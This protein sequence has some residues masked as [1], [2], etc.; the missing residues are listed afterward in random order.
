MTFLFRVCCV[1]FCISLCIGCGS[2]FAFAQVSDTFTVRTL[3]GN[4][5]TP[6]S[7]PPWL[8]VTPVAST[9]LDIAWATSTDDVA[10]GGYHVWRDGVLVATSTSTFY[11]DT[12]RTP[13]TTYT[14]Y[15]TAFDTFSNESAS[16]SEVSGTTF[17]VYV[18][19]PAEQG[20][21]YGTRVSLA[22]ELMSLSVIPGQHS[23]TIQYTT[24][25][26]VRG[27]IRYG[28]GSTYELGSLDEDV[29]QRAHEGRITGLL[30]GTTYS[31]SIEGNLGSGRYGVLYT[32]TFHTTPSVDTF[33]PGNVMNLHA[34]RNGNDVHL[35]WDNP[36]DVDFSHVRV[37]RGQLFYPTQSD[38]GWRVYD[39]EKEEAYDVGSARTDGVLYYTVFAYDA[40][41]NV[42]SGAVVSIRIGDAKPEQGPE[43]T[44]TALAFV[45]SDITFSQE[46]S[47]RPVVQ[48][49]V[50]IDGS[51]QLTV[52]IPYER[53][54]EHLKTI[55]IEITNPMDAQQPLRF[56]LRAD[57]AFTAYT[58]TIA[59]LGVSG[60]FPVSVIIYDFMT[61][62]LGARSGVLSSHL[63]SD[64]TAASSVHGRY[65]RYTYLILFIGS[66]LGLCLIGVRLVRVRKV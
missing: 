66:L 30:P 37:M 46:G 15:V 21:Q 1:V 60:E 24:R 14:Y 27:L 16:S 2:Q 39:G 65:V 56:L 6:P 3:V 64:A 54:P 53:V 31:F 63:L 51:K 17:G 29:F 10:V 43:A 61:R 58:T 7:T 12:G 26:P 52:S 38:D 40:T 48:N 33:P 42:S 47:A 49:T 50:S 20:I 41:G 9:Q 45:F 36:Q 55:I 5:T 19:P 57:S 25:N 44:S 35:T 18:P 32:G 4:D 23:A 22:S 62:N 28:T 13:S 11:S 34:V 8:T 59:P